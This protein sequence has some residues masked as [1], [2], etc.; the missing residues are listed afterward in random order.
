MLE[1]KDPTPALRGRFRKA[2]GYEIACVSADTVRATLFSERLILV[3]TEGEPE[4]MLKAARWA[5]ANAWRVA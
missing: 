3:H 2:A 5:L 1:N 4:A